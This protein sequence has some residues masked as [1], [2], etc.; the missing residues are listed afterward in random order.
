MKQ[1]E[2]LELLVMN[3]SRF[4]GVGRKSAERMAYYILKSEENYVNSLA[5]SIIKIKE[6]IKFCKRCFNLSEEDICS[7]CSDPRR[8]ASSLCIIEE[9]T[10][11]FAIEKSGFYHGLYHVLQGT[12]SP[13][14]GITP[15]YL[16]IPELLKR[17]QS[18]PFEEVI[19]A[20]NPTVDGDATA[21]Y[22][23][24]ELNKFNKKITRLGFGIPIGG[25]LE[26]SDD[27]TLKKAL[28]GRTQF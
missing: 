28:E 9:F 7:I 2:S 18:E 24:K 8:D 11:L 25:A 27:I 6:K 3:L 15:E 19:I 1:I 17:F 4:P 14:K 26:Y 20:T 10:D 16:K 12:L 5:D 23:N 21:L 13:L 22:L